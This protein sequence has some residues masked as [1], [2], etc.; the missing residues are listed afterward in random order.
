MRISDWSSD[1]CSSDLGTGGTTTW[2]DGTNT[3]MAAGG[4]G[5]LAAAATVT[6]ARAAGGAAS[7]GDLNIPGQSGGVMGGDESSIANWGDGG[8]GPLGFG[9]KS[10]HGFAGE[11]GEGYG[12]GGSGGSKVGTN[13]AGGAGKKGIVIVTEYY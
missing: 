6:G 10:S 5:G 3:L 9:G 8:S 7:G 4:A 2:S 12:S 1:V 13:R 11:A